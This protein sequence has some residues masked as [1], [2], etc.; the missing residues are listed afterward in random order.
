MIFIKASQSTEA[1]THQVHVHHSF[2]ANALRMNSKNSE[3]SNEV[4]IIGPHTNMLGVTQIR[5]KTI[6]TFGFFDRNMKT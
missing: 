6:K 5:R 3:R 4:P 1:R 2:S